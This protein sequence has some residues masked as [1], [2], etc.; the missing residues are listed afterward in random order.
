MTLFSS[1]VS[2]THQGIKEKKKK[3]KEH[4]SILIAK[5]IGSLT[6]YIIIRHEI[7]NSEEKETIAAIALLVLCLDIPFQRYMYV[8][9]SS[10]ILYQIAYTNQVLLNFGRSC[11]WELLS[12]TITYN[13]GK[14]RKPCNH[15]ISIQD[16]DLFMGWKPMNRRMHSIE[17]KLTFKY[18]VNVNTC[19]LTFFSEPSEA[20]PIFISGWGLW[21]MHGIPN[22]SHL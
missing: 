7:W 19:K 12:W 9:V 17:S 14:L 16:L 15:D 2:T 11:K 8:L 5:Q 3:S 18:R 10:I 6:G 20:V 1:I 13:L 4:F 22:S 21:I